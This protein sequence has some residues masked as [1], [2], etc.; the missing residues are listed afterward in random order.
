MHFTNA[1]QPSGGRLKEA[2]GAKVNFYCSTFLGT[3]K[4]MYSVQYY[5]LV[6]DISHKPNLKQVSCRYTDLEIS[7]RHLAS[8]RFRG[9]GAP[10]ND[11]RHNPRARAPSI[12]RL[13]VAQGN[14]A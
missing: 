5:H 12:E 9:N 13:C 3:S 1:A 8:M 7:N 4:I 11:H 14:F 10:R 2:S 6:E